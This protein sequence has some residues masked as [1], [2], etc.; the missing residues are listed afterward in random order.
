MQST[1]IHLFHQPGKLDL[2][3]L[4]SAKVESD[5]LGLLRDLEPKLIHYFDQ[6]VDNHCGI[7]LSLLILVETNPSPMLMKSISPLSTLASLSAQARAKVDSFSFATPAR[8]EVLD[9][10][11]LTNA[12]KSAMLNSVMIGIV[13][14][15]RGAILHMTPSQCDL[16]VSTEYR[17]SS[18][19]ILIQFAS[20]DVKSISDG[21]FKHCTKRMI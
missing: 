21:V 20:H 19:T 3:L 17:I 5:Q 18:N 11:R 15:S 16:S 1:F 6:P 2:L 13:S 8:R 4:R 14:V 12:L 7:L 10:V 9:L